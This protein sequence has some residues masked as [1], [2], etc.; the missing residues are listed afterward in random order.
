MSIQPM[1]TLNDGRQMPQLGMGLWQVTDAE[2][3]EIVKSAVKV[4]YRSLDTAAFYKN[5]KGIGDGIRDAGV[6]RTELFVT[7]KLWNNRHGYDE[8]FKAFDETMQRLG[9]DY[10][11]LYLIHWPVPTENRY[12]ET[13]KAFIKLRE[14]GRVKSI[15]VSNFLPEHLERIIGETGVKPV[16]DQIELHPLFQQSAARKFNASH[17]IVTEAWSPLGKGK[18]VN[19]PAIGDIAKK[20]GKSIAQVIIRWHLD[21]G[22][23]V[24][25]KS[26]N[27]ERMRDNFNVFDFK[28]SAEDMAAM[29]GLNKDERMDMDPAVFTGLDLI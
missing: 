7:T 10:V 14:Q 24:I 6:D 19:D 18:L 16:L 20:Y 15:G 4:G 11:D 12:V 2:A 22:N 21:S 23:I 27:P 25:P 8:T 28:L 5:E 29:A 3:A 17:G 26:A 13:W 9:L 1:V